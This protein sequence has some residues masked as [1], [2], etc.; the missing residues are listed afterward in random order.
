MAMWLRNKDFL[1]S[2]FLCFAPILVIYFP[3]FFYGI[4]GSKS[5]TLPPISVWVGNVVLLA[6][7]AWLLRRVLRY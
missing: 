4:D 7:G 1:T 2:F 3:L 5:G 6:A